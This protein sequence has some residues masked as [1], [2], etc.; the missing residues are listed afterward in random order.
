M[1]IQRDSVV[2]RSPWSRVVPPHDS[3]RRALLVTHH[4]AKDAVPLCRFD[5][6]D[7]AITKA[8]R[9]KLLP[10]GSLQG[11]QELIFFSICASGR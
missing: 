7:L 8:Q 1:R 5:L 3:V 11:V 10:L 9:M 2:P 6:R 4:L